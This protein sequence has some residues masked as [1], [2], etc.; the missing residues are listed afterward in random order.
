MSEIQT[1]QVLSTA[2]EPKTEQLVALRAN[3][4]AAPKDILPIG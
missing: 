2:I 1:S 4:I 3:Q